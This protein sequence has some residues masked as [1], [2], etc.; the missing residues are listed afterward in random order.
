[1][2]DNIIDTIAKLPTDEHGIYI[3]HS[4]CENSETCSFEGFDQML[5]LGQCHDVINWL[6]MYRILMGY[7]FLL[8]KVKPMSVIADLGAGYCELPMMCQTAGR[9]FN[10]YCFEFDYKKLKTVAARRIGRFNRVL[11]RSDLS[12]GIIPLPDESVD[13]IICTEFAEHIAQER[14]IA[15]LADINRI[16]KPGC[17]V[18][19]STPNILGG[20]IPKAD[21]IY[22]YTHDEFVELIEAA[23]FAINHKFGLASSKNI[24]NFDKSLAGNTLYESIREVWPSVFIKPLMGTDD[25]ASCKEVVLHC[26]KAGPYDAARIKLIDFSMSAKF[27]TRFRIKA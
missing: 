20:G 1:M 15:L 19:F 26:T 18:V 6:H 8:S 14:F 4:V 3:Q 13:A 16:C 24:R 21:H 10:Y 17:Q 11:I 2:S 12:Q 27:N 7:K 25:P 23:G 5:K 9:R 22:E